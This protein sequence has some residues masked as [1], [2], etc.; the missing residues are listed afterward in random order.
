MPNLNLD[1]TY[2]VSESQKS[3]FQQDGY[4]LLR[5]VAFQDEIALF[6]PAIEKAVA[7]HN[8][9]TRDLRDRDTY[10]KAFLQTMNLWMV[11]EVVKE[12]VLARRFAQIAADLMGV[13]KVRL[14]HDQALFKEPGGG[15]T[16]WHQDRYYWPLDTKNTITMWMPIVDISRE[17]GML[18]FA[19]GSNRS[20]LAEGGEISNQ[21]ELFFRDY[22]ETKGF[23]VEMPKFMKAGDAT[24]HSG[25]TVHSAPR[26][27]SQHRARK[28]MTIIY[29]EDGARVSRPINEQQEDDRIAWLCG[30]APGEPAQSA[31][32]PLLN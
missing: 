11:D 32:N 16:P 21:T 9:E 1:S 30:A 4:I 27:E 15:Y 14:Y 20:G 17:M 6:R 23:S 19:V 18:T 12:F 5:E 26:N 25:L 31:L 7:I 2:P 28:I 3:D 13:E 29:F 22:V 24:F 8:A 10:G